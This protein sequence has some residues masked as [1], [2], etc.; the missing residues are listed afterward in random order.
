MS[1]DELRSLVKAAAIGLPGARIWPNGLG[2]DLRG[3]A[4]SFDGREWYCARSQGE[5]SKYGT[6]G[7]PQAAKRAARIGRDKHTRSRPQ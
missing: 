7:T 4:Y 5:S 3:T 6:G 1:T 2:F